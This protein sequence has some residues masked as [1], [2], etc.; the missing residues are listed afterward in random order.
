[1]SLPPDGQ[2]LTEEDLIWLNNQ[3]PDPRPYPR[4]VSPG[5]KQVQ[6]YKADGLVYAATEFEGKH[7]AGALYFHI[8]S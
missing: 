6:V 1:M 4:L 7:R 2:A 3:D 8:K 5:Y